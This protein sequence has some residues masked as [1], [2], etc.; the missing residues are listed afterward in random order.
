MCS[1]VLRLLPVHM[2]PNRWLP[3]KNERV[4]TN[5]RCVLPVRRCTPML[6]S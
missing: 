5:G 3:A 1:Y 4:S 6:R 2:A